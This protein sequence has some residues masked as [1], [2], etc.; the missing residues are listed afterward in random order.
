MISNEGM[1]K[2]AESRASVIAFIEGVS[3]LLSQAL[4]WWYGPQASL[5]LK[6]R[7]PTHL[8]KDINN[9]V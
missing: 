4:I 9:T 1:K 5:L 3:H 7:R 2:E 6:D 8:P